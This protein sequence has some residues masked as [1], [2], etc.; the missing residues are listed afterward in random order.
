MLIDVLTILSA[1][2]ISYDASFGALVLTEDT[3]KHLHTFLRPIGQQVQKCVSD[4]IATTGLTN[5]AYTVRTL[6]LPNKKKQPLSLTLSADTDKLTDNAVFVF[7]QEQDFEIVHDVILETQELLQQCHQLLSNGITPLL[8]P[9][10]KNKLQSGYVESNS[11][12]AKELSREMLK[13]C[14]TYSQP[15]VLDVSVHGF[16]PIA[17]TIPH[18]YREKGTYPP[19][20]TLRGQV[21]GV[22]KSSS[23]IHIEIMDETGKKHTHVAKFDGYAPQPLIQA[24]LDN[25]DIEARLE[26][27]PGEKPGT[28][29][30]TQCTN[31]KQLSLLEPLGQQ[32]EPINAS[33]SRLKAVN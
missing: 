24:E 30:L 3:I 33:G 22:L 11:V 28:Y 9:K 10:H 18:G 5:G 16:E 32:A 6:I 19:I 17:L 7:S 1:H 15:Y 14:S 20:V 21:D 23:I 29:E 12:Q 13:R 31:A 4:T 25:W 2:T 27:I 26:Q 8:N